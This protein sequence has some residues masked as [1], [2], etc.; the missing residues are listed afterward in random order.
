MERMDAD[1][2]DVRA[3]IYGKLRPGVPIGADSGS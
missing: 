2:Q 1:H 3:D